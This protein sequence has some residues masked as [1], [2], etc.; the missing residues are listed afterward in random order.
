VLVTQNIL[1]K[2]KNRFNKAL[3]KT[4]NKNRSLNI[5]YLRLVDKYPLAV[6]HFLNNVSLLLQPDEKN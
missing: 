5:K 2:K 1:K 3:S 4:Y 6:L